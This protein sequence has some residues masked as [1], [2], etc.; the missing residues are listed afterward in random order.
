MERARP[1][2]RVVNAPLDPNFMKR[3]SPPMPITSF[4]VALTTSHILARVTLP[5]VPF[6]GIQPFLYDAVDDLS[7]LGAAVPPFT[8]DVRGKPGDSRR[9]RSTMISPL[10]V[11][12]NMDCGFILLSKPQ[13]IL[14]NTARG[15][16]IVER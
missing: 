6:L 16:I 12:I 14:I 13:S 5:T 4:V 11:F 3:P 9:S 1:G 2:S 10:A 7:C 15:D 8:N